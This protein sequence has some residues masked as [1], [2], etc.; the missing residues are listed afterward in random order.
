MCI[1]KCKELVLLQLNTIQCFCRRVHSQEL[2][3]QFREHSVY[4]S[5]LNVYPYSFMQFPYSMLKHFGFVTESLKKRK[6][7]KS[8]FYYANIRE[9][10]NAF[11]KSYC[12]IKDT[13]VQ[14]YLQIQKAFSDNK[15][16]QLL[17]FSIKQMED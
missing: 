13:S 9:C 2:C 14:F 3:S 12:A 16:L 8:N 5:N 7:N 1:L 10:S 17:N 6:M 4:F 15:R 11:I